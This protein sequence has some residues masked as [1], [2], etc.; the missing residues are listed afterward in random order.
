MRFFLEIFF[1]ISGSMWKQVFKKIDNS[2]L[3]VF[4]I[5]FGI[6]FFAEAVGALAL[7]WVDN[8]FVNTVTNFTFIGFEWL[9]PLQNETMYVV[10]GLMAVA[11]VGVML[12]YKY[13]FSIIALTVL[14]SLVYFGQKTSYNN[15]YYLMWL[16]GLIM[17]FLPANAY[18]SIDAK[19]N[20]SIKKNYMPQWVR[21]LF[22]VQVS[23]VYIFAT[24]A[25]FYP[26]WLDGTVTRNMFMS[27]TN[28]P[29]SVQKMFQKTEFQLFIA[30]M[31]IAFDGL[32][33]PA[34]L[35]KRTRWFAIIASL[36]FHVFNSITLQIGVFPYFALSFCVFFFPPEQIRNFFFRKKEKEEFNEE[37][38]DDAIKIFRYFFIPYVILQVILP[39]RHWFIKDDVLWTE[40]GHRL[41][42]R[43][44]LRSRSGEATFKV[45]DKKTNEQ[46]TF[47]NSELLNAKQRARL[48]TPDVIWQM[49]Q[50]IKT[51]FLAEGKEVKVFV[52][53]SK[54]RINGKKSK[55]LIDPKVDLAAEKWS[56][57]KHH[58]WILD[59][60]APKDFYFDKSLMQ[61]LPQ[62]VHQ[63]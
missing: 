60:N 13:R 63:K 25:K 41:S 45:I 28:V 18:A 61:K 30:Y 23:C 33:V 9:L 34:L 2:S 26:D 17:C 54:V 21:I 35:W 31:G 15:H 56:H 50:K 47:D 29:L 38:T 37:T 5:F 20:P 6:I 12:G 16:I 1:Q 42:W 8:N 22:I 3:I 55:K 52:R 58:D 32:I 14:W 24:V 10:F 46:L 51:H 48:N 44:M 36:I 53:H 4:R 57:F 59:Q 11:S 43:M 40:E 7:K 39:L 27:M 19:Q 62:S 49:A